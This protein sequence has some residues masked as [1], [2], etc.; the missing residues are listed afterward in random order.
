MNVPTWYS[1]DQ[2]VE[3]LI[4]IGIISDVAAEISDAAWLDGLLS[5]EGDDDDDDDDDDDA[6]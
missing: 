6:A 3:A 4:A 5:T 2:A 1:D